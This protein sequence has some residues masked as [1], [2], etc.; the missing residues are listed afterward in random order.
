MPFKDI[1]AKP[2]I[3]KLAGFLKN[4]QQLLKDYTDEQWAA[5]QQNV[6][7]FSAGG[8]NGHCLHGLSRAFGSVFR[9]QL[10]YSNYQPFAELPHVN[11]LIEHEIE[12][13]FRTTIRFCFFSIGF[14]SSCFTK[15]RAG[16]GLSS[17]SPQA[18]PA[19]GQAFT[20]PLTLRSER[21]WGCSRL[22]LYSLQRQSCRSSTGCSP[23]T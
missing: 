15:T 22:C 5:K 21:S 11:K 3:E 19:F 1:F 9:I 10:L 2:A 18:F 8:F 20:I 17:H 14:Y 6:V 23:S 16:C 4:A 12:I 7:L 13:C